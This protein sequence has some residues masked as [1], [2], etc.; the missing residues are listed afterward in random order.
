METRSGYLSLLQNHYRS[1][2]FGFLMAFASSAGQTYLVGVF[3]PGIQ[4][5]FGLSHSAW[6]IIYMV[7]TLASSVVIVWS[8]ALIAR[9]PLRSYVAISLTGLLVAC[10]A[11]SVA[12]TVWM[13]VFAVFLLRQFGQGL[14][15][16]ASVTTM[17][18]RFG[19]GA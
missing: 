10:I 6:G 3:G 18:R 12:P 17:A 4:Q 11:M 2:A 5:S 16:H 13:V 15:S 14:T 7:G 1:L 19:S 8:G 9:I